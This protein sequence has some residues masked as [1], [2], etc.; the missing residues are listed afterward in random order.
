MQRIHGSVAQFLQPEPEATDATRVTEAA[1]DPPRVSLE[2]RMRVA[3]AIA[4]QE[5]QAQED[6]Q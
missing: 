5:D 3:I 2:E 6:L 4:F 1:V